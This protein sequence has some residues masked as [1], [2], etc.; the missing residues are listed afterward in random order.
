[1]RKYC[2]A[3]TDYK[4]NVDLKD[5]T[6]IITE[7]VHGICPD[8]EVIVESDGYILPKDVPHG[9]KVKIGMALAKTVL[10]KYCLNRPVLF[11][12]KTLK[13]QKDNGKTKK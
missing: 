8:I 7:T 3:D 12:G 5:Y 13:E 10:S 4:H 6:D 11:K 2:F 9:V 1:M